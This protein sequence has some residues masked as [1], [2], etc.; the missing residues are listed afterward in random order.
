MVTEGTTLHAGETF[1]GFFIERLL[2]ADALTE[3]YLARYEGRLVALKCRDLGRA[4]SP[5]T[6]E[7]FAAG[8]TPLDAGADAVAFLRGEDVAVAMP[9]RE[10]GLDLDLLALPAGPWRV[11]VDAE[12]LPGAEIHVLERD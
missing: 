3:T 4:A 1:G 8:Y 11:V 7:A 6:P 10:G 5:P 9:L 12:L 2:R